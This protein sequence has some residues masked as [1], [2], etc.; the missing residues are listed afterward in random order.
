MP[1]APWTVAWEGLPNGAA[2]P[3]SD[4]DDSDRDI[5]AQVG[6]RLEQGGHILTQDP[7]G[8]GHGAAA[9]DSKDGRHVIDSGG[10]GISPDIYKSAAVDATLSTKLVSFTDSYLSCSEPIYGVQYTAHVQLPP[11]DGARCT[12]VIIYNRGAGTLR[13]LQADLVCFTAPAGGS[14][15]VDIHRL[16][17]AFTD[18]NT[19]GAD[20]EGSVW[21]TI[22]SV[23]AGAFKGGPF[24]DFSLVLANPQDL[25]LG[26]A[27]VFE[28]DSLN[29]AGSIVMQLKLVRVAP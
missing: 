4:L 11:V 10:A 22:P 21:N 26:D 12:G 19:V 15:V 27:W 18:P 8:V 14:L 6:L 1:L 17:S 5:K 25:V 23:A 2:Q 9:A 28:V 20:D 3:V 16:D 13:L 29:G 24:T 7:H